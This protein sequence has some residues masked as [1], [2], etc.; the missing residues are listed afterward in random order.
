MLHTRWS[1]SLSTALLPAHRQ[2]LIRDRPHRRRFQTETLPFCLMP[3][4]SYGPAPV[5]LRRGPVAPGARRCLRRDAGARG[6][7]PCACLQDA[8]IR[9]RRRG[10][11]VN[12]VRGRPFIPR[13]SHPGRRRSM[14]DRHTTRPGAWAER[15]MG[16]RSGRGGLDPATLARALGWFS[17]GLGVVEPVAARRV[18][19]AVGLGGRAGLVRPTAARRCGRSRRLAARAARSRCSAFTAPS[20]HPRWACS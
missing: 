2:N 5:R 13:G 3:S 8:R 11:R 12:L 7:A 6:E 9:R 10:S 17:I 1:Y 18:G 19:R 16:H 14:S 20:T 15:A 4:G